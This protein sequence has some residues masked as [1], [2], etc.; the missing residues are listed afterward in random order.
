ML[1]VSKRRE[2]AGVTGRGWV[3]VYGMETEDS[4]YDMGKRLSWRTLL[5]FPCGG[6]GRAK[7]VPNFAGG[8]MS[9][10]DATL[11]PEGG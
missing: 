4:I 9:E 6:M 8:I 5:S 3:Y 1:C 11:P 10:G 2:G 7:Y